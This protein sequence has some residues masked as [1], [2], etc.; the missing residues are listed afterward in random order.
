M[1]CANNGARAALQAVCAAVAALATL[2]L[3]AFAGGPS[4]DEPLVSIELRPQ[5]KLDQ[6]SVRL[7]DVAYLTTRD[8]P[9]LRR[10]MTLPLGP[11]PRP[12]SPA[13]LDRDTIVRWV[14][15][16]SGLQTVDSALRVR[17][18]AI[19]WTGASE[20]EI[21]S[22]AQQLSGE[23][24]VNAARSALLNW[25]SQRSVRAEVEPVSTVRELFL[26]PGVPK[27]RVRPLAN[28]TQPTRRML[29]WVDAW[30]DDRFVRTTAVVFEVS[31]W[32]PVAVATTNVGRGATVDPVVL[33]G[34]METR[35]VDLTTLRQGTPRAIKAGGEPADGSE[36]F[37]RPLRPGEVLTSAHLEATPAVMRGNWAH[38]LA[39]S[40]DV[41]V[42]SRVEVLQDGR[43]G[44]VVRVKVPGSSG[45][46]LA[47]V[48]GPGLVEVQP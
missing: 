24:V 19:R 44:Q 41:S 37:R 30:V 9:T 28:Q 40:G 11:A 4:P 47:R 31:A 3:P 26:P 33:R 38:L 2:A 10:L 36:R 7:G 16:R 13:V 35:E 14:E 15:A 45:E 42:E 22:A 1:V 17:S 34:A 6:S 32:A 8:L 46:V 25:L 29:V 43:P 12:G 20:T 23:T 18:S 48:T 5:V 27:L 39:R 21:E